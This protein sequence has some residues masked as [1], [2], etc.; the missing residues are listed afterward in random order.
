MAFKNPYKQKAVGRRKKAIARVYLAPGDGSF[1]IN[2]RKLEEY[3]PR[4]RS[5]IQI[6]RPLE[7]IKCQDKYRVK[8][9][10]RGGG[11]TGQAEAIRHGLSRALEQIQESNRAILKKEGLLT[12]DSRAVERKKYGRRGARRRFQFSKR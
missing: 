9:T 4:R 8:I 1:E 6:K 7:L 11:T 3:F 5:Q 10:V 12:R 2:G